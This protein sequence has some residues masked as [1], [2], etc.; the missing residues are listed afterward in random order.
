[1]S[2]ESMLQYCV[3]KAREGDSGGKIRVYSVAVDKRGNYLGEAM[4]TYIQTHPKQKAWSLRCGQYGKEYLHSEM[5]TIL[6]A[7]KTGKQ[8]AELYIARVDKQGNVKDAKPC[9]ICQAMLTSEFPDV[10]V[11]YTEENDG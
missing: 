8:I 10:V 4:N 3:K 5:H 11:H 2:I 9:V 6:K 7:A 1:M